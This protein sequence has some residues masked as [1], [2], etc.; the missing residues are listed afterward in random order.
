MLRSRLSLLLL[1]SLVSICLFGQARR[2]A[3]TPPS[4]SPTGPTGNTTGPRFNPS[5]NTVRLDVQVTTEDSHPLESQALVEISGIGGGAIQQ[6]YTDMQGRA[7][8]SVTAGQTYEVKITGAGIEPARSSFDIMPGESFHH[9]SVA[10]KFSSSAKNTAPGGLISANMLNVPVKARREFDKGEDLMRAQKWADAKKHFEKAVQEFPNYDWAFNDIGV[11]DIKLKDQAGAREA[12]THAVAI[13]GKNPE[14]TRNLA[15]MKLED[16]DFEGAKAL[17]LQSQTALPG[18]P[19]T[20]TLLAFAQYRTNQFDE[21]LANAEK[22]HRG[23]PDPD[24]LAH[25][26]AGLVRESKGDRAGAEKQMQTYL[27]EAPDSPQAQIA[28]EAL[29]RIHAQAQN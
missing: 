14:A 5:G 16:N 7:S 10:V 8:F 12:F 23:E 3:P 13:N 18:N 2:P 26:I 24:P 20:L 6:N 21:A 9:Q 25:L 17:L 28:K 27:K 4:T 1:L 11:A 19:D 15:R 22:V 29:A